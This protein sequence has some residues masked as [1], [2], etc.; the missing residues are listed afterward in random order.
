MAET[1]NF[2]RGTTAE[3]SH[4]YSNGSERE[5]IVRYVSRYASDHFSCTERYLTSKMISYMYGGLQWRVGEQNKVY[6]DIWILSIPAFTWF[7]L[8][9]VGTLRCWHECVIVGSQLI[10]VGGSGIDPWQFRYR[11][12][13]RQGIGVLDLTTMTWADRYSPNSTAY[14]SP[15]MVKD[16]YRDKYGEE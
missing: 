4:L 16:W 9:V 7:K 13:W 1:N 12:E 8:D 6:N 3:G 14:Q 10:S 11:D 15:Q 5:R 2:R